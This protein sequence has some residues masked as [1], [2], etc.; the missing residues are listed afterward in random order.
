M[1]IKNKKGGT[2]RGASIDSLSKLI[3]DLSLKQKSK[4][5]RTIKKRTIKKRTIKKRE[6]VDVDDLSRMMAKSLKIKRGP[7][8][9][10]KSEK[11]VKITK[12]MEDDLFA[13]MKE[14]KDIDDFA[15]LLES[16][17]MGGAKKT[18]KKASRKPKKK[19]EK[20]SKKK[21]AKKGG[22]KK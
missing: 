12:K 14:A 17:L 21:P 5:K 10:P 8:K 6:R 22:K 4:P 9:L 18:K 7:R 3:S 15:A 2:K 20:K 13:Q 1:G 16:E 11:P 19:M